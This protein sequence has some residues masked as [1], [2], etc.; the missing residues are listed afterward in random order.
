VLLAVLLDV[1]EEISLM[2]VDG[3]ES[4]SLLSDQFV[5]IHEAHKRKL[6]HDS[7]DVLLSLLELSKLFFLALLEAIL[8][9]LGPTHLDTQQGNS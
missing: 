4:F 1:D 2:D 9:L 8:N 3:N 5:H 7:K 6:A